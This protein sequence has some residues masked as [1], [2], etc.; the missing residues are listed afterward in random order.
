MSKEKSLIYTRVKVYPAMCLWSETPRKAGKGVC[1]D[2]SSKDICISINPELNDIL[3][4]SKDLD[5]MHIF[6][7]EEYLFLRENY[8]RLFEEKPFEIVLKCE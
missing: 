5:D 7:E 6:D 3:E 2:C 8:P 4:K 1:K